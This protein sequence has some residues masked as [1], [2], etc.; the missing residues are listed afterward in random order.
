MIDY[1]MSMTA[2]PNLHPALVH[3]P[4][5]LL[6]TAL[7]LDIAL[8]VVPRQTWLDRA[9]ALLYALGALGAVAAYLSGRQAAGSVRG[10]S[11]KAEAAMW[12]HGDWA[13]FTMAAFVVI[14]ALRVVVARRDRLTERIR[15]R[16]LRAIVL[17]A[18]ALGQGL[19]FQTADRGGALVF[20]HSIAVSSQPGGAPTQHDSSR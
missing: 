9:A 2:L 5:A 15:L 14:A 3:F 17:I 18:A 4:V 12:D 8:L 11:G 6:I 7:A 16:P 10:L 20:D 13:L 19:I 1:L